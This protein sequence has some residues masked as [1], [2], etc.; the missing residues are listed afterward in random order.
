[1]TTV[2]GG[3]GMCL[4]M[5]GMV[6]FRLGYDG[7]RHGLGMRTAGTSGRGLLILLLPRPLGGGSMGRGERDM[8]ESGRA[9]AA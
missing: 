2:G 7:S 3:G 4:G 6:L 8:M 1:M 9:G 5:G